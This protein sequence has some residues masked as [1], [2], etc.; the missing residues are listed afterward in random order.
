MLST[1]S[2]ATSLK[3]SLKIALHPCV[4]TFEVATVHLVTFL[5]LLVKHR[6]SCVRNLVCSKETHLDSHSSALAVTR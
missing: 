4:A 3:L 6:L 5:L 2:P 1:P